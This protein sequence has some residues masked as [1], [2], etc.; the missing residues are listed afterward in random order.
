MDLKR[1]ESPTGMKAGLRVCIE[2]V[3]GGVIVRRPPEQGM[4]CENS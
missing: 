2:E 1:E 4:C 3:G